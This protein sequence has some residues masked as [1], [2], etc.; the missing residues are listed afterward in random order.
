MIRPSDTI[1]QR[2]LNQTATEQQAAEVAEWFATAP[3]QAWLS[4]QMEHDAAHLVDGTIPLADRLPSGELLRRIDRIINRRRYRRIAFRIAAVLIPCA[5][6]VGMWINLN[7]R[8]G[9]ILFSA[10]ATEQAV[11]VRGERKEIIFQDGSKVF[12]NAGTQ[13]AYPLHFGLSE[14]RVQLDGEAYFEVTP[15]VKRPFV[16]QIGDAAIRVLGTSFNAKAYADDR[17]I[18]VV[19]V[20]GKVEF[21]HGSKQ[22]L[23]QPSQRLVYDKTTGEGHLFAD[24]NADRDALWRRNIISFRDTP[25]REVISTLERWYDVR[26]EVLDDS[27]YKCTFSLQTSQ[28]PLDDLLA[29]MEKIAPLRYKIEPKQKRVFIN[30]TR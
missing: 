3:G 16:V 25:L 20:E 4:E 22:Y 9:G 28:L 6:I 24:A 12:L 10:P 5:L 8:M 7:S 18:D 15:N 19:L 11:A 17:T 21:T 26:F 2:V 27:A 14:R 30:Y 29:E 13:I 1:I 23:M